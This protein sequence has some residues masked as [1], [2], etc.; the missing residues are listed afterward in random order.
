MRGWGAK[1]WTDAEADE[2]AA[3]SAPGKDSRWRAWR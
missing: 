2:G 3:G 1:E